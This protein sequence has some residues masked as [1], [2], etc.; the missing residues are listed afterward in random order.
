MEI[1]VKKKLS[2]RI[3]RVRR[4][5]KMVNTDRHRLSI[6]RSSKNIYAQIIDDAVGKTLASASTKEKNMDWFGMKEKQ[7]KF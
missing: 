6:F 3:K 5:L 1:S 7:K 4:K 2:K